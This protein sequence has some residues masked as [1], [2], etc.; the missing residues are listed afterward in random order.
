MILVYLVLALD[1]GVQ[2]SKTHPTAWSRGLGITALAV[3]FVAASI[4]Y[5]NRSDS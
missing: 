3:L 5:L 2:L 4:N 1:A